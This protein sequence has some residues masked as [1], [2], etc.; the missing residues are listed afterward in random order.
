MSIDEEIAAM[1]EE[2]AELERK[3]LI[4][5]SLTPEQE[6]ADQLHK[7]FCKAPNHTDQ[8]RYLYEKWS[9]PQGSKKAWLKRAQDAIVAAQNPASAEKLVLSI[10]KAAAGGRY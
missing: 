6:L 7:L 2:L 4:K 3:K 1:K 10:I 9:D 5:D 8:C